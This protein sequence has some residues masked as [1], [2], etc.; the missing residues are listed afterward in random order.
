MASAKV[1][2]G[3]SPSAP[4]TRVDMVIVGGGICGIL[5]AKSCV[6]RGLSYAVIERTGG[7]GGVWHT[8][9][10][11]TSFLQAFEPNYRFDESYR[12]NEDPLTKNTSQDVSY[13]FFLFSSVL[14]T[15]SLPLISHCFRHFSPFFQ[16]L[17][18]LR[19]YA[20]DY[21]IPENTLFHHEAV[22]TL[23]EKGGAFRVVVRDLAATASPGSNNAPSA[24]KHIICDYLCVT[25]G[26][27]GTQWTPEERG[28]KDIKKFKGVVTLGGRH[29][30]QDSAVSRTNLTGKRVVVMGS[31]SFA[32][33]AIEAAERSGAEHITVVGR[34]RYRWILPFS[35][36]YTISVLAQM[37]L[38][39]WSLKT[40][41]ALKYL[42]ER[43]YKPCGLSHWAPQSNKPS[44]MDFSGQ[45]NDGYFRL[46]AA[47]KLT[48][49]IDQVDRLDATGV[50]LKSGKRLPAD[51]FVCA[52]G[53]KYNLEPE[54]LKALGLGK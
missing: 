18:K 8:M 20:A 32:A 31:G 14:F 24:E 21:G 29:E 47:G 13:S 54:F 30:G 22:N 40:Q 42:R 46:A 27:L 35:R 53:C 45:C 33:E 9:A 41:V 37:P 25:C 34:P 52:S 10:N 7:L 12:L 26:I 49:V 36:Q 48:T 15:L 39:P 38:V 43:F 50:V 28:V 5:A 44:E 4:S 11:T 1:T 16:V 19:Q 6:D 17:T 3:A 23:K 51:M 2:L